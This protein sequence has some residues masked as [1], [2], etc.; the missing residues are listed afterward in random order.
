VIKITVSFSHLQ[1]TPCLKLTK[2]FTSCKH[3]PAPAIK[4]QDRGVRAAT[5]NTVRRRSVLCDSTIQQ[6]S[7]IVVE[8]SLFCRSIKGL[9]EAKICLFVYLFIYL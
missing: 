6:L 3:A 1:R 4:Q 9:Y 7:Q 8:I 2:P 5:V